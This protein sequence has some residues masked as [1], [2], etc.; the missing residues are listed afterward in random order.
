M[1][2]QQQQPCAD[3]QAGS[4][5]GPW[6]AQTGRS[7]VSPGPSTGPAHGVSDSVF[8]LQGYSESGHHDDGPPEEDLEQHPGHE[9]PA[10]EYKWPQE[11]PL[12]TSFADPHR[13]FLT[14]YPGKGAAGW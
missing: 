6:G 7:S 5:A 13:A 4:W 12:I 2:P 8:V 9:I 14:T 3:G 1:D 10:A 11:A